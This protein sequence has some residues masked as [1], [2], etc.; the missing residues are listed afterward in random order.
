[1]GFLG[2]Y[3]GTPSVLDCEVAFDQETALP[4]ESLQ[5]LVLFMVSKKA[6]TYQLP[7]L[8]HCL[9]KQYSIQLHPKNKQLTFFSQ[10]PAK[11]PL[12]LF[13]P[14]NSFPKR[15]QGNLPWQPPTKELMKETSLP[16]DETS[17]RKAFHSLPTSFHKLTHGSPFM[18]L[19]S[20]QNA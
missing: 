16:L 13:S 12:G 18:C 20:I 14:P 15:N 8:E 1:M 17:W 19:K 10:R 3:Q 6:K 9:E 4:R 11:P 2:L 7:N 5:H